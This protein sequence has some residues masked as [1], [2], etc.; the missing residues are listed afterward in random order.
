[1]VSILDGGMP[2]L[3]RKNEPALDSGNYAA[4]IVEFGVRATSQR[5]QN[6]AAN[7]NFPAM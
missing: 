2:K 1:M 7:C 3:V 6:T 5:F 4:S